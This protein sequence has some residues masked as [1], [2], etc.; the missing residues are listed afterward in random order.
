SPSLWIE[1]G[2][3]NIPDELIPKWKLALGIPE[4][5][6]T[7]LELL[8]FEEALW[9][10]RTIINSGFI[11]L[12]G[13][14]LHTLKRR[15][16]LSCSPHL[17]HVYTLISVGYFTIIGDDEAAEKALQRLSFD[18]LYLSP[19]NKIRFLTIRGTRAANKHNYAKAFED[20]HEAYIL[21]E[22]H[23][24]AGYGTFY[25][26]A[27]CL[28]VYGFA[29]KAIELWLKAREMLKDAKDEVTLFHT[30]MPLAYNYASVG[31]ATKAL[32]LLDE[33]LEYAEAIN[34]SDSVTSQIYY[35]Y[36]HAY[37]KMGDY[38]KALENCEFAIEKDGI[39]GRGYHTN[40]L[41]KAKICLSLRNTD[42]AEQCLDKGI[43]L[44]PTNTTLLIEFNSAKRLRDL[45]NPESL[46]Y[47]LDTAIPLMLDNK[48][49]D[50][51][52]TCYEQLSEYY[53][54]N[55]QYDIALDYMTSALNYI[56]KL[57]ESDLT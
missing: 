8:S 48:C 30:N 18:Y 35:G 16:E 2:K 54:K 10:W 44:S 43:S 49:Y 9:N 31:S 57:K 37:Y 20:L 51:I 50:F 19:V 13:E 33:C 25:A 1:D 14:G 24:T 45:N 55:N 7:D 26:L 4:V 34:A 56:K 28:T 6:V 41:L 39:A 42:I 36:A 21:N 40:L 23:K 32:E 29:S 5:P 3:T 38:D 22:E 52:I 47:I 27:Q 12:A 53:S 11:E 15:A 46:T 17:L